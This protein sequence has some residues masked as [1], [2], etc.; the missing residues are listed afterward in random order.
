[1]LKY[2]RGKDVKNAPRRPPSSQEGEA[3]LHLL[4]GK[5]I[6]IVFFKLVVM[7]TIKFKQFLNI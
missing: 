5:I 2:K 6:Y 7:K 3:Q 1:M 4:V